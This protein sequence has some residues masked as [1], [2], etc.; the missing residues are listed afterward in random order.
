MSDTQAGRSMNAGAE[1]AQLLFPMV[2]AI[3]ALI[4]SVVS[5]VVNY[6][7][8]NLSNLESS[9]RDTRV[10]LQLAKNDITDIKVKTIKQLVEAELAAKDQQHLKLTND[11]LVESLSDA[12]VRIN[13][14]ESQIKR[15]DHQLV[16]AKSALKHTRSKSSAAKASAK[17]TKAATLARLMKA[18]SLDIFTQKVSPALQADISKSLAHIGFKPNFP[19]HN[20]SKTLANSS[21]VFYY[22]ASYK[23]VGEKLV[24]ELSRITKSKFLLKQGTSSHEHNKIIV[25]LISQ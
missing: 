10:Q 8:N 13:E 25:H 11:K 17:K 14:L 24:K 4:L 5:G 2:I 7:Q 6:R 16:A 12:K 18:T 3:T 15:M 19:V 1:K 21:T 20:D 22:H 23:R 9:L